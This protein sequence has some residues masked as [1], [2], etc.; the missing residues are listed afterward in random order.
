MS[1]SES[2][3]AR[4]AMRLIETV[5]DWLHAPTDGHIATGSEECCVCPLCRVIAVVRDTDPAVVGTL[6]QNAVGL[7]DT[8]RGLVGMAGGER[9]PSA[10]HR[11]DDSTDA[12]SDDEGA[13]G[14]LT[15]D[16]KGSEPRAE[17]APP[18]PPTHGG[19]RRVQ[20]IDVN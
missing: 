14:P 1:E 20:H 16:A 18:V 3:A 13:A 11:S 2:A 9:A 7:L 10:P 15:S 17:A 19:A 6:T 8:V 12:D 4:E 5:Q